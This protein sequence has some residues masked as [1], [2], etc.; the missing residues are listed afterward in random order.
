MIRE[1][2]Q[3]PW[4]Q[5]TFYGETSI[6][7]TTQEGRIYRYTS[8]VTVYGEK[9][10]RIAVHSWMRWTLG[11]QR[12]P[13]MG[14]ESVTSGSVIGESRS[15]A[16]KVTLYGEKRSRKSQP[17]RPLSKGHRLWGKERQ[18]PVFGGFTPPH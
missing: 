16:G 8:K 18:T 12:S 1:Y 6:E 5:V 3:I 10:V 14:T 7:A 11:N 13:F 15:S 17:K 2:F 4:P 9:P